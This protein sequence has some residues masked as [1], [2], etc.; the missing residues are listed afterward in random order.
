LP[1]YAEPLS[2][3]AAKRLDRLGVKVM[4]DAVVEKVDEHG[5]TV[6]GHLIRSATV[7]WTAVLH[8]LRW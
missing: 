6:A 2:E 3:K 4:T 1:S 8:P 7:F 5:V